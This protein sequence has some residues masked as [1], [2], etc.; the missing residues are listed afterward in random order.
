MT[1]EREEYVEQA[2]FF[3]TLRER[4]QQGLSTQDLL[5]S[6]RQE[7]LSTTKLPMALDFMSSELKLTGG[8]SSAMARLSHYF[9]PFQVFVVREAE[10]DEGRFDIRVALE[11]LEREADYRSKGVS[12]QGVFLYQFETLCRNRLGYDRGLDAIAQDPIYDEGWREWI[13]TVRRQVGIIDIA[14]LIFVRSE[15]YRSLK[16]DPDRPILFGEKEGKI[17]L[18]NRQKDPLFLFSA[19][20]RHLGYPSVPRPKQQDTEGQLVLVVQRRLER[21]EQR[22]KLLE[23]ELRG[24]INLARFYTSPKDSPRPGDQAGL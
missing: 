11:V 4:M 5:C 18:A 17:A 6:L 19:L 23:E 2:Y 21:L 3:R 10:R 14:D 16:G 9:T 15:H 8:Y 12:P 20:A 1:L 22:L 7:I 24:G 13:V